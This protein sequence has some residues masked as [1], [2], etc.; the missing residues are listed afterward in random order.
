MH[1]VGAGKRGVVVALHGAVRDR[2]R[3]RPGEPILLPGRQLTV[4]M[5]KGACARL[6]G[7]LDPEALAGAEAQ[8]GPPLRSDKPKDPPP[9]PLH[10]HPPLPAPHPFARAS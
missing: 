2:R 5:N 3:L 1:T 8:A 6:V 7:K 9:P 10:S 4:P